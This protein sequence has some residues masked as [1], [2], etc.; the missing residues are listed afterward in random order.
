MITHLP[1]WEDPAIPLGPYLEEEPETEVVRPRQVQLL[2]GYYAALLVHRRGVLA[3]T[4]YQ[5][6]H[7]AMVARN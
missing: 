2:P 6:L 7:G 5:E 1:T 4:A 3:K